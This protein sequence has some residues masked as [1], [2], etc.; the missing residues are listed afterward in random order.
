MRL[1]KIIVLIVTPILFGQS[2][3]IH[4]RELPPE[5]IPRGT[6]AAG[7]SGYLGVEASGRFTLTNE[8][9]GGYV[10]QQ[11][12]EGYSL[13]LYPQTSGRIFAIATCEATAS[14]QSQGF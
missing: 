4:V 11:I 8:E 9:I 13:K 10:T 2:S 6:C 14:S 12:K 5:E 1:W 3:T 7:H